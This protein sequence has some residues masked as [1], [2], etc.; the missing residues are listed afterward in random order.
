[1][2]FE[3]I[4]N[5]SLLVAISALSGF[6]A[7]AKPVDTNAGKILQGFLFAFAAVVGML[8]P[9]V[10]AP[11]LIFD[12]RSIVISLC[13][14]FFGPL[15]GGIAAFSA[16]IVRIYLSGV[17][18]PMG[19]L[20][21][22]ESF[23][24]GWVAHSILQKRGL[25]WLTNLKLYLFGLFFH[26]INVLLIFTLP[27]KYASLVLTQVAWTFILV[28]PLMFFIIG[29]I[30]KGQL[31]SQ[32]YLNELIERE[33]LFRT[34]LYSIGD[35]V[36]TTDKTGRVRHMNKIAEQLTGWNEY[37]AKGKDISEVFNIANEY[38]EQP[39][40]NIIQKVIEKGIIKKLANHTILISRT[41]EKYPIAD[42]AAPIFDDM[43]E[44]RGVVITFR[45]QTEERRTQKILEEA[46]L[47]YRQFVHS[48]I[49]GIWRFDLNPPIPTSLATE[50]QIKLILEGGWLA[51]C[52][53]V[54][55]QMYGFEKAEE[56]LGI[57]LTDV[58]IPDDPTNLE[59]LKQFIENGYRVENAESIEVDKFGNRK[60][61]LNSYIGIVED[62][63]LVR[64]W[65]TQIDI[66]EKKLLEEE[67]KESEAKFR[68]LAENSIIG[69][70]LIVDNKFEYANN[71]F[72]DIC[73]Y[74]ASEVL[75]KPVLDFIHP[76][77]REKVAE[78]IRRRISG[79]LESIRYELRII[80]KDGTT[81]FVEAHGR[82]VEYKGKIGILGALI[83]ITEKKRYQQELEEKERRLRSIFQASPD[84][85]FIID[86]D[87]RYVYVAP[88]NNDLLYMPPEEIIGKTFADIFEPEMAKFFLDSVRQSLTT[89]SKVTIEYPLEIRGEK[90][91]FLA[92]IVPY[93]EDQI[94]SVI[95]NITQRKQLEEKIQMSEETY[96]GIF[97]QILEAIYIQDENGVFLDVNDG[98]VR[99]YGYPKEFF[100]GKTPEPLS[101]PGKNNLE[102]I[103]QFITKAF[104]GE[105]QKFE[106]WGIRSNGEIFPNDV[107]LYPGTYYGKKVI[108]AIAE[109]ITLRKRSETLIEI[110]HKIA[111]SLTKS[112][113]L[114]EFISSI[115]TVLGKLFDTTNFFVAFYD[116]Q[117]NL[118][119]SPY[120][121]DEMD[122][123]P[124]TWSAEKSLTGLVVKEKKS[125]LLKRQDILN[126]LEKGEVDL[127]GALPE[128]WMGVPLIIDDKSIG[129]IVIQNYQNPN[130]YND[131]DLRLF[132]Q[133]ANEISFYF[134]KKKSEE[135]LW[136]LSQAIKN[137]PLAI[138]ITNSNGIIEYVNPQFSNLTGYT[139]DEAIGQTPRILKSGYHSLEYY[140]NLWKTIKS[141]K[142]WKGE[143]LNKK[144]NGELYPD[145]NTISPIFNEKGEI[146]H[147]VGCKQDITETKRIIDELKLAKEKAEESEKLKTTFLANISHEVRS[148]LNAII[149]FSQILSQGKVPPNEI[150]QFANIIRRRGLDLLRLFNDLIDISHIETKQLS[151]SYTSS[152]PNA[153]L[154]DLFTTFSTSE[155][156][157]SK[158]LELR[159]GKT[160]PEDFIST[161]DFFRVQQVLN[162]LIHNAIKFT[163]RGY[164]EFGGYLR[165]DGMMEF[166]VKDTGVGIP[167]NK[168]NQ[169]FERF[170]K[171]DT[172][173]LTSE[174]EGLGLGLSISKGLV[175]LLGG[176]I[177]VES[178]ILKGSTFY[179]TI[180]PKE[181]RQTQTETKTSNS[182]KQPKEEKE[183]VFMIA[184]D[185]YSN[186]LL[187]TKLLEQNFKCNI[188]YAKDGKEAIEKYRT[189][190]RIDLV[191]LD[192]RLPLLDGFAVF[193]EIRKLNPNQKI[194]ALTAFAYPEDKKL[195]LRI[196]F[197]DYIAKPIEFSDT[198]EVIN[199]L[200]TK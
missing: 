149:G 181:I 49:S 34:I 92:D 95:R 47:R 127:I 14:L 8:K 160:F 163:Q 100:I 153:I 119:T 111:D 24:L 61:F 44:V 52:N 53:D 164:V 42:S 107:R 130:A 194:I 73:G 60:Y 98:A 68:T 155:E 86:K 29:Y 185:D 129:A 21:I 109:D 59:V 126:L 32:N 79:E 48:S 140:Q 78:N 187:L 82:R 150:K 97:N 156:L 76:D 104:N 72:L 177:W 99:M 51:E 6:V 180:P 94:L 121:W 195:I 64:A 84:L 91:W 81:V 50:E 186:F 110:E 125:Y 56:I 10:V 148:P 191:L 114:E 190:S 35:A 15:A 46:E 162:N 2:A 171:L 117:R 27:S 105:P 65:G 54:F 41:G 152:K 175:N 133:I 151:L 166:Y 136:K 108:I 36:I 22:I 88:V 57:K 96:R 62:G 66:T 169:I 176:E 37:S 161:T 9:V 141:G 183:Y 193:N 75:G 39:A 16:G 154:Y 197:D 132:G 124:S 55:A 113:N 118:L 77:D 85:Y 101:A 7:R 13:T 199:K 5:L 70:H 139:P 74:P 159:I 184:E 1:M 116:E 19:I 25:L 12:G 174:H 93:H 198:I 168:L 135:E 200:L 172:N 67:L 122:K 33:S 182:F 144:K 165:E 145:L 83:D 112:K 18:L 45:D 28:Y 173:F 138:L 178:K 158:K 123:G 23:V 192:I 58:F 71:A 43:G 17:G 30:L 103:K 63:K 115:R 143:L 147:F 102:E 120:E 20:A 167:E 26:L 38:T 87:G 137:S 134:L 3:I 106:F 90:Y 170:Y 40:E 4:L 31:I 189:A 11:G 69:I 80:R 146:T 188:I 131:D 142:I 179:F 196:G 89:K 128:C 157:K